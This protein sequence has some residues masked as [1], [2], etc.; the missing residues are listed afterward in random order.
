[1]LR[2]VTVTQSSIQLFLAVLTV[3]LIKVDNKIYTARVK[4]RIL[5]SRQIHG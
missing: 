3:S 1:M 4:T 2:L 5:I